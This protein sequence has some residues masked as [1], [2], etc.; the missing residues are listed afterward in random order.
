MAKF[1]KVSVGCYADSSFGHERVRT[2]LMELCCDIEREDLAHALV[3]E[4]SDDAQEEQ[5]AID[6]LNAHCSDDVHFE[7]VD[8]DL[9]LV[10]PDLCPE[11]G[12]VDGHYRQC[13]AVI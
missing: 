2:R 13:P 6:A 12:G 11:C 3:G 4:M 9:M 10:C 8:G 7:F 5:D 1:T